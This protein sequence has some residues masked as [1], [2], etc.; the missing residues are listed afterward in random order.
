MVRYRWGIEGA[1]LVEKHQGYSYEHA[2][3]KQWNA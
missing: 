2:F 1:F 3:A